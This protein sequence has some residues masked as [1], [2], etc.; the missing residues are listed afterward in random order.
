MPGLGLGVES[1]QADELFSKGGGL[2]FGSATA[3]RRSASQPLSRPRTTDRYLSGC[4]AQ[5]MDTRL[6]Q[7]GAWAINGFS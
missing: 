6:D 2:D 7:G 4:R 1:M 5:G 3:A